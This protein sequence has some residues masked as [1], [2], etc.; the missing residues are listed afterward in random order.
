MT[1]GLTVPQCD[2]CIINVELSKKVSYG[3]E[4]DIQVPFHTS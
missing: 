4:K 3:T 2:K 1:E